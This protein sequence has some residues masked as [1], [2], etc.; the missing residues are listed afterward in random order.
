MTIED[1]LEQIR[2]AAD[3][4]AAIEEELAGYKD[5]RLMELF[6]KHKKAV[7]NMVAAGMAMTLEFDVDPVELF[8]KYKRQ[9]SAAHCGQK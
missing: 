1:R 9:Q 4:K 2:A 5:P 7:I 8:R 3:T 6:D